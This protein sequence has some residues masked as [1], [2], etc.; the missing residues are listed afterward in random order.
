MFA[1]DAEVDAADDAIMVCTL[2]VWVRRPE[3]IF[4][5]LV[6]SDP[7]QSGGFSYA[8]KHNYLYTSLMCNQPCFLSQTLND[9]S[10]CFGS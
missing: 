5:V 6:G 10:I 3:K 9:G 4:Q 8:D 2:W 1:P 7:R